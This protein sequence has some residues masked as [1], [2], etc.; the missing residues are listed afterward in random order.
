MLGVLGRG[1]EDVQLSRQRMTSQDDGTQGQRTRFDLRDASLR[2]L[3]DAP[4][5]AGDLLPL[6]SSPL[7]SSRSS[8]SSRS[9]SSPSSVSSISEPSISASARTDSS[10][11]FDTVR[12]LTDNVYA[13]AEDLAQAYFATPVVPFA[14]LRWEDL[15]P[16]AFMHQFRFRQVV[17]V[18]LLTS[19]A[20]AL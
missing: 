13:Q 6:L 15:N 3:Q 18:N 14:R 1:A 10:D 12:R 17:S 2:L 9:P 11:S 8:Q 7:A 4:M 20:L 16:D 5:I 19:Y